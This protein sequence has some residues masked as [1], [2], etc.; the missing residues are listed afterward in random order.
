MLLSE[1][2]CGDKVKIVE[3]IGGEEVLKK[4]SEYEIVKYILKYRELFKLL[5][6]YIKPLPEHAIGGRIYTHFLQTGTATGRLSSK[7]PNLQ[8]IPTNKEINIRKGFIAEKDKFLISLDY[9][10]IELRLLAHFSED[11]TL[12]EAFHQ[13]KDI[14][15]ETAMKIFGDAKYRSV[16]KSIN[17]G[18]IYG[19]G[20]RKLAETINV[21]NKDAKEFI[22]RYF[23][24][25]PTVKD[26][27]N[28]QKENTHDKHNPP[29]MIT[30][31]FPSSV[32]SLKNEKS[33]FSGLI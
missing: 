19:M 22:D 23:A 9:S 8:N 31:P 24:S 11:S 30:L 25:F 33:V 12:I 15:L 18:L 21:S 14:H 29:I 7:E 16:A 13:D 27:L 4:I 26:F 20:A 3:F 32:L 17:F 2:R 10:Q 1:A 28:K 6:T 5:S